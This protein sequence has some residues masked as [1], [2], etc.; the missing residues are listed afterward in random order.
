M[1]EESALLYSKRRHTRHLVFGNRHSAFQKEGQFFATAQSNQEELQLDHFGSLLY[2]DA[3][4]VPF[5]LRV[6]IPIK[7]RGKTQCELG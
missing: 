6:H 4:V 2:L 5:P 7:N 3:P 1:P